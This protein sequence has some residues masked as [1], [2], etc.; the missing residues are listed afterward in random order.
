MGKPRK[1]YGSRRSIVLELG[2]GLMGKKGQAKQH[3][4]PIA[5]V[6]C[7]EYISHTHTPPS[8]IHPTKPLGGG[9]LKRVWNAGNSRGA[10]I[11]IF[12]WALVAERRKQ[13]RTDNPTRN[14][15]V[16]FSEKKTT[17]GTIFVEWCD[18]FS[19][20]ATATSGVQSFLI[21]RSPEAGGL[22][23]IGTGVRIQLIGRTSPST[24]RRCF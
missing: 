21:P 19:P 12:S 6:V 14:L 10:T 9:E 13:A 7:R 24:I 8:M 5:F 2:G 11:C 18:V 16:Q 23:G 15:Q 20:H 3:A 22:R 4:A 1:S 17:L